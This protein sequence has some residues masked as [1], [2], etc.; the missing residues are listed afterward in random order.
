MSLKF[1]T[2][3]RRR[4][5]NRQKV[6]NILA[7]FWIIFL[8]VYPSVFANY[9]QD[10]TGA[11]VRGDY[12]TSTIISTYDPTSWEYI[13]SNLLEA[14]GIVENPVDSIDVAQSIK[15]IEMV[16]QP[17]VETWPK[18]D[19][20]KIL[21]PIHIV[22][23]KQ[24]L[25]A[26]TK[27]YGVTLDALKNANPGLNPDL[28]ID[29][30]IVIPT[31]RG[32]EYIV[33]KGDTLSVI[34]ARYGVDN[35]YHILVA[36]DLSNASKLRIGQKLL[37]PNPTK[38]PNAKKIQNTPIAA[39]KTP[40][41]SPVKAPDKVTTT[42]KTLTYGTYSL[43]LKVEKGCR[44]FAWGNCTCFVAKYKNVTWRG[45]AKQWLK[46][47]QKAGAPTGQDPK[48]GAIIVYDGYGYSPYYGHVG[49]VMEVGEDYI[50][51]KDMNY[52]ALNQITTRREN[53]KNNKAIKGY[54]YVD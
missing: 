39:Q 8:P 5:R 42:P 23:P 20:K 14:N 37:L 15:E 26:I 33:K 19:P 49:I 38:D 29:Q 13:M 22:T 18:E 27:Q 36:N 1:A 4:Q 2:R 35:L 17:I 54:I 46:N 10:Y 25:E 31:I 12:D 48:P 41:K 53:F 34:A 52:S 32:V 30:K 7:L 28:K 16:P 50:I 40:A 47:A 44:N 3:L 9:V 45:N 6:L 51:V 21:Y 24:T 11:I 43:N